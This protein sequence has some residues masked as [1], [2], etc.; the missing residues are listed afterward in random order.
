M[1]FLLKAPGKNSMDSENNTVKCSSAAVRYYLL[2]Q[3]IE[4]EKRKR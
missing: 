1:G 3:L 2:F 4:N